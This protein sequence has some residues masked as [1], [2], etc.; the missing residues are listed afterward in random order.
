MSLIYELMR[1]YLYPKIYYLEPSL[2][3]AV[4][5]GISALFLGG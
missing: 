3:P 2:D 1:F 5:I 4:L